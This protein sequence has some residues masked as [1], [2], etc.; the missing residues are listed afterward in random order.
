M[1]LLKNKVFLTLTILTLLTL[2]VTT[3]AYAITPFTITG[4][5]VTV[6]GVFASIEYTNDLTQPQ[7]WSPTLTVATGVPFYSRIRFTKL[8]Y[9]GTLVITWKLMS[10][11][12]MLDTIDQTVIITTVPSDVAPQY[13]IACIGTTSTPYSWSATSIGIYYITAYGI[14]PP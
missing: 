11:T 4:G 3:I 1:N 5:Q 7:T 9:I 13:F 10:G 2:A 12:T 8:D 6:T 14:S